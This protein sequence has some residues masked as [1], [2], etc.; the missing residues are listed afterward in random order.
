MHNAEQLNVLSVSDLKAIAE[1]MLIPKTKISKLKKGEMIE[2]I[3]K[4]ANN[5]TSE[6]PINK[7]TITPIDE[8]QKEPTH[9][10]VEQI[11]IDSESTKQNLEATS[12]ANVVNPDTNQENVVANNDKKDKKQNKQSCS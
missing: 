3:L 5:N 1:S 6:E 8:V 2:L 9:Q 4:Q 11:R 7:M 10:E 12:D